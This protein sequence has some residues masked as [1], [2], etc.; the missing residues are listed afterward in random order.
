MI[1]HGPR[2]VRF[3]FLVG[4]LLGLALGCQSPSKEG[5]VDLVIRGSRVI[6]PASGLDAIRKV[7]EDVLPAASHESR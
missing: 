3:L 6:D 7:A 4:L 1:L 5:T 2:A